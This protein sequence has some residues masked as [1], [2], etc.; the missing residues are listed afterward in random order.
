MPLTKEK[1]H[2][3]PEQE[4]LLITL[5]A[6][7]LGAPRSFFSDETAWKIIEGLDYDFSKLKVPLKTSL[8]VCM[9][10]KRLDDYVSEFLSRQPQGVVLHLGCGLDTRC[11]RINQV[12]AEWYDLDMPG[13][14][15]LRQ[16]FF[17]ETARY[18]M[19]ASSVTEWG[20]LEQVQGQ[21]RPAFVVAEGLMMYLSE[22]EVKT[23]LLKLKECFPGCLLAFDAFSRLTVSRI[24]AHPSIQQT[25]ARIQWG[26]DDAREI[27]AWVPG[28][29][30]QEEWFMTQSDMIAK[31]GPA[32]RW[33]FKLAGLFTAA[34]KAQ[35]ILY[36]RY[37]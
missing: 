2:L 25:G 24:H 5:Y 27:E 33:M 7:T 23:L 18:H 21:G 11:S 13:V 17:T 28:I 6:K 36:Y 22:A 3:T 15:E 19:L 29:K 12:E 32:Y 16:N 37:T 26:I 4:T 30:L 35:R 14:I 31:L 34:K 20:W 1:I 8:T 9:R 10:A